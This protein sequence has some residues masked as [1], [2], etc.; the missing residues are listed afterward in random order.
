METG[1]FIFHVIIRGR[2]HPLIFVRI[3]MVHEL[4]TNRQDSLNSKAESEF[5]ETNLLERALRF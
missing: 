1:V 4:Q 2:L 5:R 3:I